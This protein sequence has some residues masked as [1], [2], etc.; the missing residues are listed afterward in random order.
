[1]TFDRGARPPPFYA[2]ARRGRGAQRSSFC[3]GASY[4]PAMDLLEYQGKQR[5]RKRGVPMPDGRHAATV[6]EALEAAEELGFP[7]VI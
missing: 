2:S 5:F 1:M 6:P 4:L 3:G 7:V